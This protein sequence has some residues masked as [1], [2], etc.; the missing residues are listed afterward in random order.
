MTYGVVV[1]ESGGYVERVDDQVNLFKYGPCP[2]PK[3]ET[4]VELSDS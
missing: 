3:D 1:G 2:P 4:S